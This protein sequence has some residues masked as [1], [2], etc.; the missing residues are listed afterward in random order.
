MK[1]EKILR[2]IGEI[3][4]QL[5]RE[6]EPQEK[7]RGARSWKKWAAL[8][9]CL[10]LV[11]GVGVFAGPRLLR[12]EDTLAVD[13]VAY[14]VTVNGILYF[15]ISFEERIQYGL[16][17]EGTVGL[18]PENTYRITEADLGEVIGTVESCTEE[19]MIGAIVYHFA[20]YPDYDSICIVEHH[21]QYQFYV[22]DGVSL[23]EEER[24]SS[25]RILEAY[26]IP[27]SVT[28]IT[29]QNGN[30]ENLLTITDEAT[31]N[32]ICEIVAGKTSIGLESREALFAQLWYD[33]Y[34]NYDVKYNGT[35]MSYASVEASEKAAALW[36]SNERIVWFTTE[37]GFEFYLIYTPSIS[38]FAFYDGYFVLSEKEVLSLNALLQIPE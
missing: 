20:K 7:R 16:V 33:T 19:S 17:E 6:A 38:S 5:V 36:G 26:E 30:W 11:V 8:A 4:E 22:A 10:C 21:G 24:K 35:A 31:I 2:A 37:R 1:S 9:A 23:A 15:P 32:A 28:K 27:A 18:T 25:D 14:G 12:S 29:V 13:H 3:D 34:G